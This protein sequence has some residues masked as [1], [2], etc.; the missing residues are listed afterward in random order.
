MP[1]ATHLEVHSF[2]TQKL[3]QTIPTVKGGSCL[4]DG[5]FGTDDVQRGRNPVR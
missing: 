2:R 5:R 1:K 3:V 4:V